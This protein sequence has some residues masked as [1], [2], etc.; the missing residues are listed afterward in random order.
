MT[1]LCLRGLAA[2]RPL[3][4]L[5]MALFLTAS[6]VRADDRVVVHLDEA[7]IIKLPDRATTVVIGNPLIADISVQPGN[8]AVVTGKSYGAT[9]LIILDKSGAV[10]TEHDVEVQ[11]STD[12]IV[13]VYRGV[14]RST[15][16]CTPECAARITLGDDTHFF[17]DALAQVTSRNAQSLAA[18][19]G[20]AH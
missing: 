11:G 16:S 1:A 20:T 10:L 13:V 19:A 7:R 17:T 2:L 4:W 12:K 5:A 8:L 9:N 3:C 18:G 6:A 15:Y 14:N